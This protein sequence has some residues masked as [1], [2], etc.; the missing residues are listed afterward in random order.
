MKKTF[1][2]LILTG[3]FAAL[4]FSASAN[5][6]DAKS[7]AAGYLAKG[8]ELMAMINGGKIDMA[9][10][11]SLVD[12][13]TAEAKA[14]AENYAKK[15]PKADKLVKLVVSNMAK[16]KSMSFETLE[17]DWHDGAGID[18]KAV[19]IDITKEE[20][21]KYTDP[22][23]TVVHPYMTLAALKKNDLKAAKEELNEG[24]EQAA[25]AAE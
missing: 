5:A 7:A 10:A 13:I 6:A 24:M 21:E 2:H 12:G 9:K 25:K 1:K 11:E 3:S 20:N 18:A 19:G 8:K 23:H 22:L 15:D 14:I 16:F 4:A 17:K